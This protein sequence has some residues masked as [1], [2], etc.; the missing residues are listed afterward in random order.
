MEF[1]QKSRMPVAGV[2][3]YRRHPRQSA[4]RLAER[5]NAL[6]Y[7]ESQPRPIPAL[8]AYATKMGRSLVLAC[9]SMQETPQALPGLLRL[10]LPLVASMRAS[11]AEAWLWLAKPRP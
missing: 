6:F 8:T 4:L 7:L 3:S 1:R 10:W 11:Q 5:H 9:Q 2:V